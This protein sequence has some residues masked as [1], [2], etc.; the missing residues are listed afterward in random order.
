[1]KSVTKC[2]SWSIIF[3]VNF[4]NENIY[5]SSRNIDEIVLFWKY[6]FPYDLNSLIVALMQN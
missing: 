5:R 4:H 6:I 1:M 2:L 3:Y